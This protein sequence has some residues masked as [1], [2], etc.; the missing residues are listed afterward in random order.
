MSKSKLIA[1][2]ATGYSF[3]IKDAK[4]T[5]FTYPISGKRVAPAIKVTT[6]NNE[7]LY[8]HPDEII[9]RKIK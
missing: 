4:D 2:L 8:Y 6:T 1:T 7:T 3:N 9:I 5:Y